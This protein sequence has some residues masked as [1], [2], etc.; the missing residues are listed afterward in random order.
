MVFQ[1][2][3]QRYRGG[4]GPPL[5]EL[6]VKMQILLINKMVVSHIENF[7]DQQNFD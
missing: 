7:V 5:Q 1:K 4:G 2:I 3:G 6:I